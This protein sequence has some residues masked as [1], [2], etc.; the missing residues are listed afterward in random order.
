MTTA[1]EAHEQR[2]YRLF[3]G[4]NG[5]MAMLAFFA[6]IVL[7]LAADYVWWRLLITEV[8]E[9][10]PFLMYVFGALMAFAALSIVGT[11]FNVLAEENA[12]P[13][14][15][16]WFVGGGTAIAYVLLGL[17]FLLVGSTFDVYSHELRVGRDGTVYQSESEAPRSYWN[18][19]TVRL[20]THYTFTYETTRDD[21]TQ[22]G[23][24]IKTRH[25]ATVLVTLAQNDALGER[26]SNYFAQGAS[27]DSIRNTLQNRASAITHGVQ[28]WLDE[29]DVED[30]HSGVS[31]RPT[32]P[33]IESITLTQV[34]N[35]AERAEN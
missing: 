28:R 12:P 6:V 33:W 20:P 13:T 32:E 17:Y 24:P 34:S 18:V 3:S 23:T 22:N 16:L 25:T 1:L 27:G 2:P 4:I 8:T 29:T 9:T 14:T 30:I 35:S 15:F 11:A 5:I 19:G 10:D 7:V 26:V 31:F 21:R